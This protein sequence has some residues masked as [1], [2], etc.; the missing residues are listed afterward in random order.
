MMG[1]MKRNFDSNLSLLALILSCSERLSSGG[2]RKLVEVKADSRDHLGSVQVQGDAKDD[3]G[4]KTSMPSWADE[5]QR[6]LS[7][8]TTACR[9][10]VCLTGTTPH[11]VKPAV[12][13]LSPCL[14]DYDTLNY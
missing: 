3:F 9:G 1:I 11:P 12:R 5:W 2:G 14:Y 10:F 7:E 4:R 13:L 6:W 8:H